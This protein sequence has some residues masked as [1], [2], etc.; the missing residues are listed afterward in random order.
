MVPKKRNDWLC[1]INR[2]FEKSISVI[3]RQI[4]DVQRSESVLFHN[5]VFI[6]WL[7]I[8]KIPIK[9]K[10]I[11]S[12]HMFYNLY[13]TRLNSILGSTTYRRSTCNPMQDLR[14]V[15]YLSD[16]LRHIYKLQML[17]LWSNNDSTI[18]RNSFRNPTMVLRIVERIIVDRWRYAFFLITQPE[19]FEASTAKNRVSEFK[20]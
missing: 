15:D 6:N 2:G 8:E 17:N 4:I 13:S 14:V 7:I 5:N 20:G 18:C 19:L 11:L 12:H 16:I 9:K 3:D 10:S 1:Q